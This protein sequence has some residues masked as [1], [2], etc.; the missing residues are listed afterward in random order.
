MNRLIPKDIVAQRLSQIGTLPIIA[1][2]REALGNGTDLSLVGG[3]V[4]DIAIDT[5]GA[6]LDLATSLLPE[7]TKELLTKE[8]IRVIDTGINHGTVTALFEG[9]TVEITTFRAKEGSGAVGFGTDLLTDLALRDFTINAMA[10][11]FADKAF[12]DPFDGLRDLQMGIIRCVGS[13]QERFEEDPLRIMRML[14]LGPA[15]GRS[16]ETATKQAAQ[17]QA[18]SLTKVSMERVRVEL[19]RILLGP[20]P[21]EALRMMK[22]IKIIPFVLPELLPCIDFEQNEFH[23]EDVFEHTLTVL[24]RTPAVLPIRLAALF[25]DAG[26]PS[27]LTENSDGSRHFYEHEVLSAE[28]CFKAMRRLKFPNSLIN[29]VNKLVKLHM[30]PLDCGPAGVRRLFRDLK[31]CFNDW[32][33]LKNADKPPLMSQTTF[34]QQLARFDRIVQTERERAKQPSYGKLKIN[35]NDL[36]RLGFRPGPELGMALK[37][38]EQLVIEDPKLNNQLYLS[39]KAKLLLSRQ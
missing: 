4:R 13:A 20:Y 25:H 28:I 22:S 35:G 7:E 32:M 30:R 16:I 19:E 8:N 5:K 6:D 17:N 18:A 10:Y 26:K 1:Q 31:D 34:Q 29:K 27:T 36:I 37:T 23:N 21:D 2:I 38:L 11:H 12:I 9:S 14:R 33:I 24:R 3:S 15:V 39:E